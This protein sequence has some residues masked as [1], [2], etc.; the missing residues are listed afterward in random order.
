MTSALCLKCYIET[1]AA[2]RLFSV[3][4]QLILMIWVFVV[5]SGVKMSVSL[6]GCNIL[7]VEALKIITQRPKLKKKKSACHIEVTFPYRDC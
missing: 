6:L 7:E 2:D 4:V 3:S 1:E 5:F